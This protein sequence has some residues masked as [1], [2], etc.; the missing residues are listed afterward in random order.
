MTGLPVWKKPI[1]SLSWLD[2]LTLFVHPQ[3]LLLER[4]VWRGAK[5]RRSVAI[6]P[7]VKG[8]AAW[9]PVLGGLE[10]LLKADNRKGGSLRIVVADP[11]VRYALL[12][13]SERIIGD[14]ARQIMAGALLKNALGEKAATLEI[15]LDHAA[16]GRNGIAA[17]IDRLFLAG[18]RGAAK[19]Q[20]L[21]LT[22]LQPGMFV[23][24]A[25]YRK[26]LADGWFV[27]LDRRWLALL[28]LRDGEPVSLRNHRL[29]AD[30][31]EGLASELVGIL[32]AGS[33]LAA[34]APARKV[35]L[36]SRGVDVPA[37]PAPWEMTCWPALLGGAE[38]A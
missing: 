29:S 16:F 5:T 24:L 10:A 26:Q 1:V 7:P 19:A 18:L 30:D 35:F 38:D 8:E 27:C 22:G 34:Q 11:L 6:A 31:G 4:Q 20:R 25:G 21:R 23:E 33:A 17:G 32:V 36:V 15:A 14:K 37:L 13:W 2:S 9:Q 3:H 12:P 28:E